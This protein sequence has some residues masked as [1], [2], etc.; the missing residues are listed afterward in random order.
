[1]PDFTNYDFKYKSNAKPGISTK[2]R[3]FNRMLLAVILASIGYCIFK[4]APND[5]TLHSETNNPDSSATHRH[6]DST[7]V[8]TQDSLQ[9]PD[10]SEINRQD[11]HGDGQEDGQEDGQDDSK[12]ADS[13]QQNYKDL[14]DSTQK[15]GSRAP[16]YWQAQKDSALGKYLEYLLNHYKPD[17][18]FYLVIDGPTNEIIA[19]GQRS[20][21]TVQSSPTYLPM[22]KFP[23]ASLI[24]AVTIGAV[25]HHK[26]YSAHSQI[27]LIGRSHTLYKSQLNVPANYSGPTI[28]VVDAFAKSANPV[29]GIMGYNLGG[30]RLREFG[31]NMGFNIEWPHNI[32]H[33][34]T[35]NPPDNGYGL[36]EAA[37]GFTKENTISPLLAGAISRA[38]LMQKKLSMPWSL[39][40]PSYAPGAHIAY[41]NGDIHPDAL[42]GLR[43]AF[44]RTVTHGTSKRSMKQIVYNYNHKKFTIGGKTG[45]LDGDWPQK[46][47]YDWFMGFAQEKENPQNAIAIVVMQY[48]YDKR[49][50]SSSKITGLIINQWER[51]HRQ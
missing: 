51:I 46:A 34:S 43:Q 23:A 25:M 20:D 2:Q 16:Q 24:K 50:L 45:T 5:T 21:S 30:K 28:S 13:L 7:L 26:R 37:S 27:P 3:W 31:T 14:E 41:K 1:L 48:H 32:P 15:T 47:R 10:S 29:F 38:V 39:Q 42:Q 49:T 17:G 6:L 36:A 33:K 4:P 9:K 35:F 8:T 44:I 11:S 12:L 18:A 40:L 19:W 22:S